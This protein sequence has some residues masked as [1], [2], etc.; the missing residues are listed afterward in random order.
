MSNENPAE[1]PA[2]STPELR[3]LSVSLDTAF[4]N[5]SS[6]DGSTKDNGTKQFG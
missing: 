3:E 1:R 2:W 4:G 5:G 6:G